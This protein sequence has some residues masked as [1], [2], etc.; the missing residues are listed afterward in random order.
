MIC[1]FPNE[2][3]PC[4]VSATDIGLG[5][6]KLDELLMNEEL[7]QMKKEIALNKPKK[8][9]LGPKCP[10]CDVTFTKNQNRDHVAWHFMEELREMVLALQDPRSCPQCTYTSD[11]VLFYSQLN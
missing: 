2:N 7:V 11:K 10:I 1:Y 3:Y 8:L 4:L 5:H 9:I 6:S